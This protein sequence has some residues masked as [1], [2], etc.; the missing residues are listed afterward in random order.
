MAVGFPTKVNY[1][2]GD[3]LSATNMND[4]S[5]TVNLLTGT[6]LAAGKNPFLNASFNVWQR[7]T[8]F[9]LAA[10]TS[11]YTADR[12]KC[13]R[14]AVGA[15]I[16]RQATN[17]TTNLPFI[18][19]ALRAQRDSA[20]AT[21]DLIQVTQSF[22]NINSI[23]YAGKTL[24]LSFYARAGANYSSSANGLII[25]LKSGTVSNGDVISDTFANVI[26]GQTA[27]LTTTWQR[28]TY[29][30]TMVAT[31]TAIGLQMYYT[32]VGTAS[33]NDYFEVTGVQL[34]AS[35]V[36]SAYAPNGATY[37][38]ELAACQRYLPTITGTGNTFIGVAANTT[39]SRVNIPFPVTARVLPTGLTYV[40]ALSNYSLTNPALGNGTPTAI[41]FTYAGT[42]NATI[43][44]T[45]TA[46]S[47]TLVAGNPVQF[48]T[49]NANAIIYFTGCEL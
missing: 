12:W 38:A 6:Q 4:L 43:D 29:T 11:T 14:N 46:G 19:Y 24:T 40:G 33:T 30:G 15:T 20:N 3:V 39:A 1:A 42:T 26:V 44:V 27:T 37:Q 31:D 5:G 22:E 9:A 10:S 7:G 28:F 48:N 34:E 17:D 13:R 21:T 2:T 41:A 36:A 45:T 16:S 47:P 18:Q 35:T 25:N 23:P 8:S 32:P 49:I